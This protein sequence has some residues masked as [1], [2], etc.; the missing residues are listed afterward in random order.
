MEFHILGPLEVVAGGRAVDLG[1]AKQRALLA[2]LAINANHVVAR[3]QLIEA[4]WDEEPPETA[5]KALQVYVSQLRK[6][7]GRERLETK[8]Q[9]VPAA[10]RV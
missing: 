6:L 3:D 10:S 1:G 4:L 2:L 9:R 7:L 8:S 5:G